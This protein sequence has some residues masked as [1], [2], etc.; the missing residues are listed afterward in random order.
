MYQ[1]EIQAAQHSGTEQCNAFGIDQR[2][3]I[4]IYAEPA[5]E[6]GADFALVAPLAASLGSLL[7]SS[8]SELEPHTASL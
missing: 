4:W 7:G 6:F 8:I 2:D 1:I 3:C 5:N